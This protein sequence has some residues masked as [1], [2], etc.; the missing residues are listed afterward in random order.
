MADSPDADG[1]L[2]WIKGRKEKNGSG[3]EDGG[4]YEKNENYLYHGTQQ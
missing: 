3:P 1:K 2:L 4:S